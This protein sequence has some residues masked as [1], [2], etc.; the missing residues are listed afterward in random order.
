[1]NDDL[2]FVYNEREIGPWGQTNPKRA[3]I[4]TLV[5]DLTSKRIRLE[6]QTLEGV[7]VTLQKISSVLFAAGGG[8]YYR[9]SQKSHAGFPYDENRSASE[10]IEAAVEYYGLEIP[11]IVFGYSQMKRG[12]LYHSKYRVPR[13]S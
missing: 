12:I 4:Y 2:E 13:I 6:K 8:L 10:I 5:K 3:G 9:P 11:V 1:M 7:S